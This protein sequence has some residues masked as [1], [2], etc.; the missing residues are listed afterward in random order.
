[1]DR[2]CQQTLVCFPQCWLTVVQHKQYLTDLSPDQSWRTLT[3]ITMGSVGVQRGGWHSSRSFKHIH[4]RLIDTSKF[5]AQTLAACL[6]PV[7]FSEVE[8]ILLG[9]LDMR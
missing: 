9:R 3:N 6:A 5:K 4:R 7:G 8:D 2:V 1:M